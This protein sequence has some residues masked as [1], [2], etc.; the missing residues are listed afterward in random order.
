MVKLIDMDQKRRVEL[1]GTPDQP[2]PEEVCNLV[3]II[4]HVIRRALVTEQKEKAL[5]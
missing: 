5:K 2:T 1:V 4:A 3:K